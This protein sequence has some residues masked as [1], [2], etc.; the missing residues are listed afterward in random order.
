MLTMF[1][2][3]IAVIGFCG[4]FFM[5]V[6]NK[7][8]RAETEANN[9]FAQID[10]QLK[11]RYDLIP[12]LVETVKGYAA[13]EKNTLEAVIK[14]RNTAVNVIKQYDNG[15]ADVNQVLA[16]NGALETMLSRLMLLTESY[17]ELKA[18]H[19]F[20]ILS[21]ELASTENRIAY[22]RQAFNDSVM[23]YNQTIKQVPDNIIAKMMDRSEM[24]HLEVIE[25]E[26][27]RKPVKVSFK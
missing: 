1:L 13:H 7:I 3:L 4:I 25:E 19:Q 10:V 8:I 22:A 14:A 21:D 26:A 16:S 18:D 5:Q 23:I 20:N 6:Y 12:N 9:S 11:R 2:L 15:Q 27:E 24:T 17:P